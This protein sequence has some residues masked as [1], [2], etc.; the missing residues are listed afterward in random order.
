V[1]TSSHVGFFLWTEVWSSERL[2][3]ECG[4]RLATK[5]RAALGVAKTF[6]KVLLSAPPVHK[7]ATHLS[8]FLI[9]GKC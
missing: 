1:R 9:I 2:K 8:R 5:T 7:P 6:W 4:A 3:Q